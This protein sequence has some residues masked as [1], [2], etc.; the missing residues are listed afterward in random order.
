MGLQAGQVALDVDFTTIAK[1][2]SEKPICRLIQTAITNLVDSTFTAV[3]FTSESIDTD[4]FFSSG[5]SQTRIVP[6][7]PGYYRWFGGVVFSAR[8]DYLTV[9]CIARKNGAFLPPAGRIGSGVTTS[10]ILN[11][12]GLVDM[13]GVDD[14]IELI[15]YQDNTANAAATTSVGGSYSSVFELEYIRSL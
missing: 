4:G 7:R 2:S 1:A 6:N 11:T 12:T 13:D 9:S 5:V 8:S 15:A 14:Y 3:T 10:F